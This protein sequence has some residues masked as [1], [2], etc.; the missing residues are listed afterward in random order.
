MLSHESVL[1]QTQKAKVFFLIPKGVELV[2]S[3]EP[4]EVLSYIDER[5]T[6]MEYAAVFLFLTWV[7]ENNKTFK[8]SLPEVWAK[9]E[10][11]L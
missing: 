3:Y 6:N 1:N 7:S 11:T 5:L 10:T 2:G 4:E 9:W 8:P